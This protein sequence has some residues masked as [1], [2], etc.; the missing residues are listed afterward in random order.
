MIDKPQPENENVRHLLKPVL[1]GR[2]GQLSAVSGSALIM[3]VAEAA[4]LVMVTQIAFAL[5]QGDSSVKLEFGPFGHEASPGTAMWLAVL[6]IL[7]RG[8]AQ[9]LNG[10]QSAHLVTDVLARAR[11]EMAD[12][13]LNSSWSRQSQE[14][15]GHLQELLTTYVLRVSTIVNDLA[16]GITSGF[17]LL[18]LTVTAI[19]VSPI[20]AISLL[21]ALVILGG[22]LQPLRR[23]IRGASRGTADTSLEFA[24]AVSEISWIGR[25]VQ[26]FGVEHEVATKIHGLIVSNSSEM[27]RQR[28][29]GFMFTPM[30]ASVV[31]LMLIGALAAIWSAGVN[32]LA[33]LGAVM[34]IMIRSLAYAQ[35]A[36]AVFATLHSNVPY[37][38]DLGHQLDSYKRDQVDRRGKDIEAVGTIK[39]TAVDFHYEHEGFSLENLNFTLNEGESIGI[40]G[41]SGSGKSTLIQLLLRLREPS[42]GSISAGGISMSKISLDDWRREVSFV[43]QEAQMISGTVADNISFFRRDFTRKDIVR[44]AM[45]AHIH[46]EILDF[47]AGYDTTI[48]GGNLQLSGGQRQRICI[49]RALL[50]NPSVLVLDEPTSALDVRSEIKVRETLVGLHGSTTVVI[51]AHRLSTLEKCDRIMVLHAGHILAFD[52]PKALSKSSSFYQEAVQ[53]SGLS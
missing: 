53:F 29:L 46:G 5:S 35:L 6:I 9:T 13:Y 33:S 19:F 50:S 31:L 20:A 14:E 18:A 40:I 32:D 15:S 26:T 52:S 41:P 21:L 16:S 42:E 7:V 37:M 25:E 28:F 12:A 17:S 44:A 45:A 36:Q 24:T 48:G 2:A 47:P 34:V 8:A 38:V 39:F 4:V 51:I 23:I 30:Y 43:P 1:Q 11:H 49:A 22:T 3:G 10:W 27:R